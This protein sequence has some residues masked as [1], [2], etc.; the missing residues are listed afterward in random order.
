MASE[1]ALQSQPR[2]QCPAV[3]CY[4]SL[5]GKP[6]LHP[7]KYPPEASFYEDLTNSS[8]KESLWPPR[9]FQTRGCMAGQVKERTTHNLLLAAREENRE[10]GFLFVYINDKTKIRKFCNKIVQLFR[11]KYLFTIVTT[12]ENNFSLNMI[13]YLAIL[14]YNYQ[15]I[16]MCPRSYA[17]HTDVS[18]KEHHI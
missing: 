5:K 8:S 10:D 6:R 15:R 12:Q 7:E 4:L 14:F 1:P 2:G 11:A 18:F 17:R 13:F 16:S 9:T 3:C